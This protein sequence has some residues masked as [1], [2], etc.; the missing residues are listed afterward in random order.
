[1]RNIKIVIEYD[2]TKYKGWQ[3]QKDFP[4]IQGE[5]EKAAYKFL[6][7]VSRIK[8]ASRTDSGVHA[9]AQVANIKCE[10]SLTE[11]E[12]KEAFNFYL[13]DDIFVKEVHDV[14]PRFNARF[15]A[16]SKIYLYRVLIGYSPLLFNRVWMIRN[17]IDVVLMKDVIKFFMSV[18]DFCHFTKIYDENTKIKIQRFSYKVDTDFSGNTEYL[19]FIE[20]PKFLYR[21]VRR[22]IG[23]VV[24]VSTGKRTFQE[25]KDLVKGADVRD[26]KPALTSGLYLYRVNYEKGKIFM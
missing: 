10:S 17:R 2:G 3:Y 7:P 6:K 5:I 19:F 4:T 24:D 25:L 14:S 22:I 23:A 12:I 21:M 13:P 9:I 16:T 18:D 20:A 26:F 1:M 8:G 11:I 15:S